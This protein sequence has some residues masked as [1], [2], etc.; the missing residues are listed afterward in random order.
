MYNI[1]NFSIYGVKRGVW[2][3]EDTGTPGHHPFLK[4]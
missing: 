2:D 3:T 4:G 1:F